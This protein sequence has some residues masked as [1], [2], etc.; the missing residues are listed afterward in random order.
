MKKRF[1]ERRK[2]RPQFIKHHGGLGTLQRVPRPILSHILAASIQS[3]ATHLR[4]R[5]ED[6]IRAEWLG[7]AMGKVEMQRENV[8]KQLPM[9]V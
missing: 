5:S 9:L 3:K 2:E 8:G 6:G 7:W 1:S 4:K